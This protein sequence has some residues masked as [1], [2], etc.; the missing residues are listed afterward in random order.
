MPAGP[1]LAALR[2]LFR[3]GRAGG[4]SD[5]LSRPTAVYVAELDG[6]Q[7]EAAS[8]RRVSPA[9]EFSQPA[10]SPSGRALLYWGRA[11]RDPAHGVWLSRLSGDSRRVSAGTVLEGHPAWCPDERS[12]VCFSTEGDPSPEPWTPARQFA[13]DRSPRHLWRVDLD[14]GRRTPITDGAYV[15]ERPCVTPDGQAVCF[16]SNRSGRLNLWTVAIDGRGLRQLTDGEL[17]YRPA[18]APDGA[19]LAWFTRASRGGTHQLALASW[20]DVQPLAFQVDRPFRWI[21]GPHWLADSRRLL[22]HGLAEG[23]DSASLWV[24]DTASGHTD[25]LQ[26]P[27]FASCS[28]GSLD[29]TGRVLAFDSRETLPALR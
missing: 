12:L 9:G 14:D 24:L 4:R 1:L 16:V 6:L 17:D 7:A 26:V 20:P 22:V 13:V 8:V 23:E 10:I 25:R 15:D 2:R 11:A 19:R 27:G 18:I 3:A 5:R 21:H 29:A 28:H